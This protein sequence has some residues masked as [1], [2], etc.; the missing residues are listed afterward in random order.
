MKNTENRVGIYDSVFNP[1]VFDHIPK[2]AKVLDVGCW[3]GN[4]GEVLIA[5][6]SR[7]VDGIDFNKDAL[8]LAAT[9]GYRKL[10][11]IDL[12]C[13]NVVDEWP[14]DK[15]DCIVFADVLE[16]TVNP[17]K[18]LNKLSM[19][20]ADTGKIL[21]SVPNIAFIQQRFLHLL[22]VFD[23]SSRGGIMD[24]THL[25]FF[26][27]KSLIKLAENSGLFIKK[28]EGYSLVKNKYFFLRWLAKI[29]PSLFAIQFICV[30]THGSREST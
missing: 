6:G 25:H 28:I 10:Y 21:I 18:T 1:I 11:R 24:H 12:N 20:L 13:S 23:Y 26:T 3:T 8:E 5:A 16:H 19:N 27:K 29:L 4:L 2:N 14:K 9:K 17:Q 22:G 30:L 15:Y 7:I